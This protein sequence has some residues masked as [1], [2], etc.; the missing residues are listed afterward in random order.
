MPSA[1]HEGGFG[2]PPSSQG[3]LE[4]PAGRGDSN[5]PTP[6]GPSSSEPGCVL[7]GEEIQEEEKVAWVPQCAAQALGTWRTVPLGSQR[8]SS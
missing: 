3:P 6:P 8:F 1:G 7:K 2:T 4:F 5:W